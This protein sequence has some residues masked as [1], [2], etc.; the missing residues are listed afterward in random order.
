MG[1]RLPLIGLCWAA[2]LLCPLRAEA[3]E[4]VAGDG[5]AYVV[6]RQFLPA[7]RRMRAEAE[8]RCVEVAAQLP[9][10]FKGN[11]SFRMFIVPESTKFPEASITTYA[12]TL[13]AG[14]SHPAVARMQADA[15]ETGLLEAMSDLP[16]LRPDKTKHHNLADAAACTSVLAYDRQLGDPRVLRVS[17]ISRDNVACLVVMDTPADRDVV[18]GAHWDGVLGSLRLGVN[19]APSTSWTRFLPVTGVALAVLVVLIIAW[20]GALR[21]RAANR[22][23]P[24]EE[25]GFRG[26]TI[27]ELKGTTSGG[28]LFDKVLGDDESDGAMPVLQV[29]GIGGDAPAEPLAPDTDEDQLDFDIPVRRFDQAN[30][31]IAGA[32][33]ANSA[34]DPAAGPRADVPRRAQPRKVLSADPAK[35]RKSSKIVRNDEYLK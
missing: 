2:L 15:F 3:L 7:P 11:P 6:P 13:P 23:R 5:F 32:G 19:S 33:V 28:N 14:R 16:E 29:P 21:R 8:E 35:K 26:A 4:R 12:L 1:H 27:S 18:Y 31:I 9:I 24:R 25:A 10:A 30:D 17:L 20:I 34:P 22:M